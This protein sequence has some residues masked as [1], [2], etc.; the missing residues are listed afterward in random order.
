MTQAGKK[1]PVLYTITQANCAKVKTLVPKLV[2]L[3]EKVLYG[4][5]WERPGLSKRE[6]SMATIA[7]L[8]ALGK[9]DQLRAHIERGAS[10]GIT[11]AKIGELFTH[12]A[13]YAG[14]PAAMA[15][16]TVANGVFDELKASKTSKKIKKSKSKK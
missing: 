10:Y 12:L 13:F 7:V 4:D 3:T 6:R 8:V 16:A 5:V 1:S 2:E 9:P 14:W 15:A 11:E